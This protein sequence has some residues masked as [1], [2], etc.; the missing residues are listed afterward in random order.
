A[1]ANEHQGRVLD[2]NVVDWTNGGDGDLLALPH[3]GRPLTVSEDKGRR[4]LDRG[5][6]QGHS[7]SPGSVLSA[8]LKTE[9][10]EALDQVIDCL[11]LP[12]RPWSPP[13]EG[14]GSQHLNGPRPMA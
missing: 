3:V 11:G 12:R 14:V 4:P 1:I 6:H 13:F 2:A 5:A 8:G 7:L 10:L 9:R